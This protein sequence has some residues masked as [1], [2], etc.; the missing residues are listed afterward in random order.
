MKGDTVRLLVMT[1]EPLLAEALARLVQP[2]E[3]IVLVGVVPNLE[4]LAAA[5]DRSDV[6]LVSTADT[7]SWDA[8]LTL[9]RER[10]TP[11]IVLWVHHAT[12]EFAHQAVENGIN[13]ILR[14]S[15]P[16]ET[17]L[18]CVRDVYDG[19]W[20]YE[21]RL[22]SSLHSCRVVNLSSRE[23]DLVRLVSQ[24]LKNKEIA[25]ELGITEGTVKSYFTRVFQKLGAKD[26]LEVAIYGLQHYQTFHASVTTRPR[27]VLLDLNTRTGA[28]PA[29]PLRR[30]RMNG[31][32]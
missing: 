6:L 14:R 3:D 11:R 16:P 2:L 21:Q 13:G 9:R 28:V 1:E 24:G 22:S 25:Y 20:W 19:D 23:S 4:E 26:R 10:P 31:G 32:V 27:T 5:A 15:L 12:V 18:Q 29:A 17:I 30:V 7:F 8:L